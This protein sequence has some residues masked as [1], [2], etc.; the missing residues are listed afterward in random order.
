MGAP[1]LSPPDSIVATLVGYTASG[2]RGQR[3]GQALI[4]MSFALGAAA[5]RAQ[6]TAVETSSEHYQ[7]R[8]ELGT[9][10][11]SNAHRVEQ[12]SSAD[13]ASCD[14]SCSGWW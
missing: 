13:A 10:F 7:V 2:M 4:L 8:T 3:F 12:L 14:R 11:D 6:E 9:E 5:A 1:T